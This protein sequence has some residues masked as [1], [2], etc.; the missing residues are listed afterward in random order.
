MIHSEGPERRRG[1]LYSNETSAEVPRVDDFFFL[2]RFARESSGPLEQNPRP[3]G[4]G[5][6][7]RKLVQG[8]NGAQKHQNK[9]KQFCFRP[10]HHLASSSCCVIFMMVGTS[11]L[12]LTELLNLRRNLPPAGDRAP[13]IRTF[14]SA[15]KI[16]HARAFWQ[17]LADDRALR[18]I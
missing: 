11:Q 8:N 15:M 5:G 6:L 9:S 14:Q 1:G 10:Y 3:L 17:A 2:P 13:R 4:K 12:P 18:L 7:R 16:G